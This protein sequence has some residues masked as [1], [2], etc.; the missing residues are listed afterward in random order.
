MNRVYRKAALKLYGLTASD[1]EWVLGR[2]TDAQGQYLRELLK[3]LHDIG[4]PVN[5][6]WADDVSTKSDDSLGHKQISPVQQAEL[7][8]E[9]ADLTSLKRLLDYEPDRV[10]ALVLA[11]RE[12]SWRDAYL[13]SCESQ[14]RDYLNIVLSKEMVQ[15]SNMVSDAL[16]LALARKL[17]E[18]VAEERTYNSDKRS[19]C[20]HSHVSRGFWREL[21]QR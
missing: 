1:R 16:V 3:E 2:L 9:S 10:V 6:Q 5:C 11:F 14:R 4:I 13:N 7:E 20:S 15:V 17:C 21:W 12:W 8:I 18:Q 19:Y